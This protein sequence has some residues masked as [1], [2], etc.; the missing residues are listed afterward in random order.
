MEKNDQTKAGNSSGEDLE[1]ADLD[2]VYQKLGV[3]PKGLSSA[4]AKERIEKYG[5]NEL[6]DKEASA[7]EKF[8]LF[9]WGPIA[10]MIEAAA[11]LSLLMGALGGSQHHP[12]A[13]VLQRHLGLLA[14]T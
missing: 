9:F 5:R 14:G 2:T 8:L 13:A 12:G 1:K 11:V 3:T 7:L 4:E 10:W 6:V